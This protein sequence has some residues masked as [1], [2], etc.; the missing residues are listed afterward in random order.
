MKESG[1]RESA[2][3]GR[4]QH[5]RRAVLHEE[6]RHR[7]PLSRASSD[8]LLLLVLPLSVGQAPAASERLVEPD[9]SEKPIAADLRQRVLRPP[10]LLL[11]LE[12]L[13][14]VGEPL[15]I[16]TPPMLDGFLPSLH[17]PPLPR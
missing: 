1:S 9:I 3:P 12:H 13:A 15:A 7:G 6:V 11:G 16:A 8:R 5:H 10:A 17:R 2:S 14:A 4:P